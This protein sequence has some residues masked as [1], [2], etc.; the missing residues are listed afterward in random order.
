[1]LDTASAVELLP[2]LLLEDAADR[3]ESAGSPA[4]EGPSADA[5]QDAPNVG[6]WGHLGAIPGPRA[7]AGDSAGARKYPENFN[8]FQ[9]FRQS[10]R[11]DGNRIFLLRSY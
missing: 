4:A 9:D 6:N 1:M 3:V 7:A 5:P 10:G 2:L 11:Q 8:V